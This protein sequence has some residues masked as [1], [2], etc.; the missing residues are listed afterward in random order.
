VFICC[1]LLH[2]ALPRKFTKLLDDV[3]VKEHEQSEF[4]CEVF[5]ED[6]EVAWYL[7]DIEIEDGDMYRLIVDGAVR[8]FVIHDTLKLEEG[9]V[10]VKVGEEE[11]NANLTV[12]GIDMWLLYSTIQLSYCS[13]KTIHVYVDLSLYTYLY[14]DI[15]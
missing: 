5:P 4:D 6:A 11:C 12:E 14:L 13:F 2:V 8:K 1:V 7:N 9:S 15:F 10:T 3:S